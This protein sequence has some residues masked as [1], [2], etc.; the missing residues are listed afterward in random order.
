MF[1]GFQGLSTA[2]CWNCLGVDALPSTQV[3]PGRVLGLPSLGPYYGDGGRGMAD[4][5][6]EKINWP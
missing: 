4:V 3:S 2:N 6:V 1:Q 5:K